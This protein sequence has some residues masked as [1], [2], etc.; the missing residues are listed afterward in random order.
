MG[1][2]GRD[3]HG[4]ANNSGQAEEHHE[5]STMLLAICEVA[6]TDSG[7]GTDDVWGDTHKLR[8][9]VRVAHVVDDGGEEERDRVEGSVDTD[10]DQ[11]VNVDLPVLE[12]GV[13][14]LDVILVGEGAAIQ[15]EPVLDFITFFLGEETGTKEPISSP[16]GEK[17]KE[18]RT[19]LGYRE[20]QTWQ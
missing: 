14:V 17:I 1:I 8:T 4:E 20:S 7:D 15:L 10:S 19:S 11:H 16:P 9:V 6:S 12:S 13:E 5:H 18:Q 3:K 2:L